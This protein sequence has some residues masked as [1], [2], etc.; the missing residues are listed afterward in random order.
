[1]LDTL[2]EAIVDW[3]KHQ[4]PDALE[5]RERA[6]KAAATIGRAVRVSTDHS[7]KA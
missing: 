1:M 5:A 3:S 2:R 4:P 6:M 7:P